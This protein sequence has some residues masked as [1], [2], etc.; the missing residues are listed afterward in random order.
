MK[1][2]VKAA[3]TYD[4]QPGM[5]QSVP[6]LITTTTSKDYLKGDLNCDGEV[7]DFELLDYVDQWVQGLVNDLD[8]LAAIN[9][10]AS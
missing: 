10:W 1:I 4:A 8:L 9:N 3:A 7:S 5:A 2:I 6:T